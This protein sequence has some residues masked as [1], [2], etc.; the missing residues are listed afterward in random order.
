M[1][2][3]PTDLYRFIGDAAENR[4]PAGRIRVFVDFR[5]LSLQSCPEGFHSSSFE[6]CG[7]PLRIRALAHRVLRIASILFLFAFATFGQTL[8][9]NPV[10]VARGSAN[11]FRLAL[12]P[13]AAKPLVALQW[14]FAY[15]AGLLRIEPS[16]V[17][18]GPA[19]ETAGKSITCGQKASNGKTLRLACILAGGTQMIS[20]GVLAIVRADAASDA[21]KGLT[22]IGLERLMG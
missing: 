8:E 15:P 13:D 10:S 2:R 12:K 14:E 11:I 19:A 22:T 4:A 17:V 6:P 1:D 7:A 21:P 20:A 9:A 16:G 5:C 18:P 3:P